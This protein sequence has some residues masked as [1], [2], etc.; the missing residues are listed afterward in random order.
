MRCLACYYVL[1][2]A[3]LAPVAVSAQQPVRI[4]KPDGEFAEPFSQIVSVRELSDGRLLVADPREKIVQLIDFAAG[5][6]IRIG[7][8]GSG[9]GEYQHPQRIIALPGDTSAIYDAANI[10]YVIILPDGKTG[11]TFRLEDLVSSGLGR[12]GGTAPRGTDAR[13]RFFL[14]DPR[15]HPRRPAD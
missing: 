1:L 13:G 2:W 6:A 8:E 4:G 3:A 15:S 14:R 12:P 10:R 11:P 7:R 9:P 5:M